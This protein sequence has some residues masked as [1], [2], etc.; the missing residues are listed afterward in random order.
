MSDF[1][2]TKICPFP[3]SRMELG[4]THKQFVP[5]CYAW[6]T[7][8][9]H[10]EFKASQTY[11]A[12]D[13]HSI[14]NSKQA[15][16][17]RESILDGSY[18]YCIV[19]RCNKPQITIS[20]AQET[21]M[22]YFETPISEN[23]LFSMEKSEGLMKDGPSSISISG[24]IKCNLK[25]PTC[26]NG[27]VTISNSEDQATID[28]EIEYIKNNKETI[29]VIKMANGGEAFFSK[30]QRELLRSFNNFDFP[31]LSHIFLITNGLLMNQKNFDLLYPGSTFIKKIA[32][33]MDAGNEET[34]K[35]T[36]G[37]DWNTLIK[38]LEWIGQKRKKEEILT[39]NYNFVVRKANYE[40]IDEFIEIGRK[41]N[42]DY[43]ELIKYDDW[44]D[45]YN[46]RLDLSKRYA[47]EAV[48]RKDHPEHQ[49][50]VG[51]LSKYKNDKDVRINIDG[52]F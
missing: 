49:K 33:S 27:L 1:K 14:W 47:E 2:N 44:E 12:K 17:L 18:K 5:C 32:I 6:F 35:E 52:I 43:F 37:G 36:R 4:L 24:D 11:D 51:I 40:S 38:N 8:E 9:Y 29:Q 50:L 31:N 7:D 46:S 19:D 10:E 34:Y 45:L 22:K 30:D 13:Y 16:A 23:N 25:C 21:D 39:L 26:R 3:F 28:S 41:N 42:V 48:H 20:E 15:V